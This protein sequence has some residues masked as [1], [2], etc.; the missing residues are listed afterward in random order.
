[1]IIQAEAPEQLSES[2]GSWTLQLAWIYG[3]RK[4][5]A[6]S[7]KSVE[8][9][10]KIRIELNVNSVKLVSKTCQSRLCWAG[11][12]SVRGMAIIVQ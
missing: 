1:M 9:S 5:P 7:G 8:E 12:T 10:D 3:Q 6:C 4:P 2:V 11:K